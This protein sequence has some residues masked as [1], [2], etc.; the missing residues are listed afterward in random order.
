M[1]KLTLYT[2]W[3]SVVVFCASCKQKNTNDG[4]VSSILDAVSSSMN[5]KLTCDRLDAVSAMKSSVKADIIEAY[6]LKLASNDF[7]I[8]VWMLGLGS[9]DEFYR[10]E[11]IEAYNVYLTERLTEIKKYEGKYFEQTSTKYVGTEIE[12]ENIVTEKYDEIIDQCECTARV[13]LTDSNG[14][15]KNKISY[16]L[17]RNSEGEIVVRYIYTPKAQ[18]PIFASLFT[19]NYKF[20]EASDFIKRYNEIYGIDDNQNYR[21]IVLPTLN[22][23]KPNL[24]NSELYKW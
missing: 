14:T 2:L 3:I 20:K 6:A 10:K 13:I 4:L 23:N 7:P 8:A 22:N 19:N 11:L 15:D 24:P 18:I 12:L 21:Q 5:Q 16:D 1:R 9:T 17:I